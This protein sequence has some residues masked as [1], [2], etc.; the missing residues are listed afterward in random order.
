MRL[1]FSLARVFELFLFSALISAPLIIRSIQ[2]KSV[3]LLA[4][5]YAKIATISNNCLAEVCVAIHIVF[6]GQISFYPS[7][8]RSHTTDGAF[9][10]TEQVS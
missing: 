2:F 8:F 10:H 6:K 9:V 7:P 4:G 3:K 5:L 1:L